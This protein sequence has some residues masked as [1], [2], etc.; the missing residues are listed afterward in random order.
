MARYALAARAAR[1]GSMDSEYT[2]SAIDRLQAYGDE[3]IS[4]C[5]AQAA[6][7][8][9]TFGAYQPGEFTRSPRGQNLSLK[10]GVSP[11]PVMTEVTP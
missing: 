2:Q 5:V 7:Q 10:K 8:D 3:R 1:A 9:S 6:A 11:P 4:E